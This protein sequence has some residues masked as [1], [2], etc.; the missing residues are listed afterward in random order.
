MNRKEAAQI[1]SIMQANYPDSFK[2]KSDD[3]LVATIN[4]WAKMFEAD[5]ANEVTAAVMAHMAA[6]T[7]RFMPPVG[8]IKDRLLKLRQP[9]EMT[10]QEAW[11]LVAEATKN[12]IWGAQEEFDKLPPVIQ[13]IVGSPNQL[14]DWAM[15][16]SDTVQSVVA[17]NFQRSYKVRAASERELLAIPS[18]VRRVM[19]QIAAGLRTPELP[20][21]IT[22]G[23]FEQR[24]ARELEKLA[25]GMSMPALESGE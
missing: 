7:N 3:M 11:A 19:T 24:R 21:K 10:E 14:R 25:A 8:V 17:S 2:G 1:I 16:D 15:M 5:S 4:L 20:G 12:G 22:E 6:D 13:R 23:E 18:D 9:D